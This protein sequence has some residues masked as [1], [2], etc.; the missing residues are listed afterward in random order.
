MIDGG[1]KYMRFKRNFNADVN[2]TGGRQ[3]LAGTRIDTQ[4]MPSVS[5]NYLI[6][7]DWSAYAQVAKGFQAPSEANSFY[8]SN[9]QFFSN[10]IQI[11]PETSINYQLGTVFKRER[12]NA[13]ADVYFIN[14]DHYAYNG[15]LDSS[16]DPTYYGIAKGAHFSGVEAEVTYY[17]GAGLSAYANGSINHGKFKGSKLEVPQV[18]NA[19]AALGLV[20]DKNGFF[21][22]FAEKYVGQWTVYDTITNPDLPGGGASRS[23]K[24]SNYWLGDLS[25]G[26][27]MKV[28]HS[29]IRSFKVRFQVGNVF[30]RKIQV[31]DGIDAVAANAYSKD[32]FNVLP[33]RNYFLTVSAEF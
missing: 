5:A 18:P 3:A 7:K 13:D 2:Q 15:P 4:T 12:F 16:G 20:Y 26:Y 25:I 10:A 11:K 31:L 28:R 9:A 32:T 30:N 17:V 24:S 23:A 21:G 19:T 14:F 29:F 27:G 22:S 1:V 8:V 33:D 6:D